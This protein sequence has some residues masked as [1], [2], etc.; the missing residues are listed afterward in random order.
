MEADQEVD[1]WGLQWSLQGDS[2]RGFVC[3]TSHVELIGLVPVEWAEVMPE[4]SPLTS[5]VKKKAG[6][7]VCKD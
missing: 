6:M 1:L 4:Y 5:K 2:T 7:C 3:A